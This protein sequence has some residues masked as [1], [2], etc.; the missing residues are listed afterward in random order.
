[1]P[2]KMFTNRV[3]EEILQRSRMLAIAENR[4][5]ND[6]LEEALTDVLAKRESRAPVFRVNP[7]AHGRPNFFRRF[8]ST[9]KHIAN[10][11]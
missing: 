4:P 3:E 5:F 6:L 11:R 2:K 1:M 9:I 7:P 10:E 8:A